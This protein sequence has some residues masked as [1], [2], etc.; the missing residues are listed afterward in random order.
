MGLDFGNTWSIVGLQSQT[1]LEQ[2]LKLAGVDVAAVV[3]SLG[4][5]IPESCVVLLSEKVVVGVGWLSCAEGRSLR[6]DGEENNSSGKDVDLGTL[7]I[8]SHVDFGSHM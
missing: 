5:K 3:I 8:L 6:D 1:F 7:V 4:M 2:V